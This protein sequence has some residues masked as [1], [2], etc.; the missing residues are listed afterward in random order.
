MDYENARVKAL[1]LEQKILDLEQKIVKLPQGDL[2]CSHE[3]KRRRW[4]C[5]LKGEKRYLKKQERSVAEALAAK[6][7]YQFLLEEAKQEKSALDLYL[8]HYRGQEERQQ[9]LE[10]EVAGYRELLGPLFLPT[11]EKQARWLNEPYRTNPHYQESL[12][13]GVSGEFM[14]SKSEMMIK[15][16]LDNHKIASR[17]ECELVLGDNTYYPDFTI[18]HPKTGKVI[19]WEHCG[20]IDKSNYVNRTI[21]KLH[22][23]LMHGIIPT[24]NLI[25]TFETQEQPLTYDIIEKNIDMYLT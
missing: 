10:E 21:T 1:K 2:I 22:T 14:R 7:Y 24:I 19:Y 5:K 4:F 9:Q 3:K 18:L 25:L 20:R 16:A 11:E 15:T 6:R 13:M 23:Y 8:R 12:T 17:Y